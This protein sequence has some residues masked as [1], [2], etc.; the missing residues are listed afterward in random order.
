[1]VKNPP[2]NAEGVGSSPG[3]GR[4]TGGGDDNTLQCSC[5]GN[6]IERRAWQATIHGAAKE[7]DMT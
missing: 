3:S 5:L 1:M 7:V 6:P 4:S 2:V